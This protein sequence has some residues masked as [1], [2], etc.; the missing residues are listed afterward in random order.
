MEPIISNEDKKECAI[1]LEG[2]RKGDS[3]FRMQCTHEFH[4]LCMAEC[5]L[6]THKRCP[7]CRH[8]D[9]FLTVDTEFMKTY[10]IMRGEPVQ[11]TVPAHIDLNG[12]IVE[13]FE[14]E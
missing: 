1:C 4:Y 14:G 11:S 3:I 2:I 13:G 7:C 10:R 9:M 6:T 8:T 5:L 12:E